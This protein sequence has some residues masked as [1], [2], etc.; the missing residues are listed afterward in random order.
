[1][2][3][4][5]QIRQQ[6]ETL[7]LTQDQVALRAGISKP[8]LSNI[9]NDKTQNPP[10]DRVL[11]GLEKALGFE[12]GQM[13]Y[14]A[15]LARTPVDIRAKMEQ[16]ETEL[17]KLKNVLKQILSRWPKNE[18]GELDDSAGV[19]LVPPDQ[20]E[21]FSRNISET[22]SAGRH[23]PL[24]NKVAAGYPHNFTDL[25]YPASIADDYVRCPDISDKNAFAARVVGDSMEPKYQESDIVIFAP[26][27]VPANGDDCFVRFADTY[28]TTFKR[29]YR[30][31]DGSIRLQPLNP[32]YPAQRFA[33]ERISGI[34]PAVFRIERIHSSARRMR[35]VTSAD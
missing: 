34:Y 30:D 21:E 8:Y 2:T 18:Q 24:I 25:D 4:G 32:D 33:P 20:L 16:A 23:V 26:N 6:R 35:T 5:G 13:L 9:E 10:T 7:S 15:H 11:E 19:E 28:D 27:S 22:L 29:F 3:L 14:L 1:M 17:E 12:Q 31:E